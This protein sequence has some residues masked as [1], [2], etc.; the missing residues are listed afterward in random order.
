MAAPIVETKERAIDVGGGRLKLRFKTAGNGE[1]IVYLHPA[2]GLF[3]DPFLG[4]LSQ[5]RSIYAPEVPGTSA[6]DNNAI[7]L[8]DDLWDL[9]LLYEEGIRGLG[10]ST[11]PVVIGQSFGGML[12][13]ELAA[14]FPQL[15]S[16]VILFDP[17]GLR[18]EGLPI[19][20]WMTTPPEKLPAL[21][22]KNPEHPAAKAMFTPPPDPELAVK[23]LSGLV[24]ALGCTGKFVWPLADK[25][26]R[27]R[28]H[29]ITA[30][31]LIVWGK[32]DALI[33]SDYARE[34]G[35]AIKG[36]RVEIIPDCGH[37]P[38]AEQMQTTLGLVQEFLSQGDS[39]P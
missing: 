12:A 25:G 26:L 15:F 11:A 19:T 6:G 23:L 2:G 28:L 39:R 34:F 38:Q 7:H 10:L 37:I 27:K 18:R 16:K 3:F 33:P 32:D 35:D 24:W 9:V 1:P 8:V 14:H 31:T 30:P 36:S 4:A 5:T 29:R 17:I 20:N 13:A 21:L 22:F